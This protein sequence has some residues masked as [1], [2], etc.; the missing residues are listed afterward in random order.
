MN[1][2]IKAKNLNAKSKMIYSIIL[3]LVICLIL[4]YA[5]VS[6]N[7]KKIKYLQK[8]I[9]GQKIEAEQN[10][11]RQQ[12]LS[13]VTKKIKQIEAQIDTLNSVFIKNNKELEFITTLEGIAAKNNVNQTININFDAT[14]AKQGYEIISLSLNLS[15]TY[16][17]LINFL[18]DLETL[19][20][21][22]NIHSLSLSLAGAQKSTP[23]G[24]AAPNNYSMTLLAN[25]YWR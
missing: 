3:F 25:T 17:N 7:V 5:I 21:Y 6:P 18:I 2:K 19:S 11:I 14:T 4:I 8:L 20:Y 24:E 22:I 9:I 10:L 12:N 15:G 1:L 16:N 13:S 23:E